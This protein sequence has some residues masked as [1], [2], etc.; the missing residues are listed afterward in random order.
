MDDRASTEEE[1]GFK[2]GVHR[3]VQDGEVGAAEANGT[4][5]NAEVR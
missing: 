2:E 5:H 4:A 1:R 3:H